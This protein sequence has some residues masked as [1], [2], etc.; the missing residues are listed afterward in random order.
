MSPTR[1]ITLK[2]LMLSGQRYIGL[3]H[4][5]EKLLDALVKQLPEVRRVK[6]Y[7]MYALPNQPARVQE[8]FRQ[9]KSVAYINGQYFFAKKNLSG[10]TA[11]EDLSSFTRQKA[12]AKL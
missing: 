4:P 12:T 6:E 8:V 1:R 3:Q 10:K 2:H 5:L 11:A 9:F 7:Q